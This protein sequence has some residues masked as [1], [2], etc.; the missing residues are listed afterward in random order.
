MARRRFLVVIS[1][2]KDIG[3][4]SPFLFIEKNMLNKEIVIISS[5]SDKIRLYVDG[6]VKSI[7]S[8]SVAKIIK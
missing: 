6:K 7:K 8:K 2:I 1:L 3:G 4:D 5:K